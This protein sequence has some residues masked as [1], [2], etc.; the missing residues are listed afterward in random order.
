MKGRCVIESLARIMRGKNVSM[1]VKRELKKS[2]LLPTLTYRAKTRR[3]N[4][5]QQSRVRVVE[6]SYQRGACGVT[7]GE[8]ESNERVYEV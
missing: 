5:T 6:M 8:H 7:R 3:R 1:E 2:I 4:R